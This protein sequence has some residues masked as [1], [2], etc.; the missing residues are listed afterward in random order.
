[1]VTVL[2]ASDELAALV[3]EAI[4]LARR[5]AAAPEGAASRGERRAA[6]RLADLLHGR[7]GVE[8][9]MHFVD[10]VV[11]PEDRGVAARELARLVRS[12]GTIVVASTTPLGFLSPADRALLTLGGSTAPHAP[13]LVVPLAA[14]RVRQL[15]GHLVLDAGSRS[16][17]QRLAS[18]RAE[19]VQLNLN[20]L[21]EAVLGHEEADRRLAAIV[22]LLSRPDVDYVSVKASSVAAQLQ[23]WDLVGNRQRLV[24]R[25]LPL[26]RRAAKRRP[27]AFLNLDMEEYK[28]LRLTLDTFLALLS[29]PELHDLSAGIVLQTYLPDAVPALEELLDFARARQVAGGAPIKVR[30]VKGANL[31]MERVEA[32]LHGWPQAPYPTKEETDANYLR[33]LDLALRP[34]H[35]AVRIGVASHNLFHVAL[36]HLLAAARGVADSLDVEMLQGMAPAQARAVQQ[37]CGRMV[38]YTP[39]V[40]PADFDEAISYLVRRLEENAAP[41]NFLHA[42]F[43]H[44]PDEHAPE[45]PAPDQ[46]AVATD[47]L[48]DQE[49]RFRAAI[50]ARDSVRTAPR[51]TQNRATETQRAAAGACFRNEPD[52]DPSLPANRAWAAAALARDP[53]PRTGPVLTDPADVDTAIETARAAADSW[54]AVPAADRAGLLR[55]AADALARARGDLVSV[56]AHEAGKTVTEADPEVSEAIDF[57][58]YY[59]DRALELDAQPGAVFTPARVVVVTPPW[60]FPVAIPV[61]G[62]CAALAAG[63]TVILKPAPQSARCAEVA[64][65]ALHE[66]G[67]RRDVLQLVHTDEAAAGRRLVTAPPVDLVVLTGA[68]ETAATFRRWRPDLRVLAETSGKNALVV[69][70]AA[71][72]DLAV[73]DILRSAFGHAGQKCSAASLVITVGSMSR[74]ARFRRQLVDGVRSL[75]CGPATDLATVV[76]PLIEPPPGKL[77]RA[78][79]RLEPGEAWLV[80]PRRLDS[81]GRLWSPGVRSGVRPDSFLHLT[82]V[83]GPVLALMEA[84]DLDEAIDLQNATGFGLTGGLHSLDEDEIAHWLERVEVG[85]TYVNR[86]ITGAIVQRQSF[87]GWK[88][89]VVGPAAK[90]GGPNY[91]AQFGTWRD[92]D[93]AALPQADPAAAPARVLSAFA[94]LPSSDQDWLA[95]AAGSD[96][97][98]W[99]TV[100]RHETDPTGLRVEANVFRYRPLPKLCVR[101]GVGTPPRHLARALLAAAVAAVPGELGAAASGPLE[102][103][104]GLPGIEFRRESDEELARRVGTWTGGRRLRALGQVP[105]ELRRAAADS[106]TTVLDAEPLCAGRRELLTVLREQTISRT[107]H[108]F[109]YLPAR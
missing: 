70:P 63:S 66:A 13:S 32:E 77:E 62:V 51:R 22:E 108:R 2:R 81:S 95:R 72:I 4:A 27:Q 80:P 98:A 39:V 93:L 105:T 49:R 97:H 5:W 35:D 18:A 102:P 36:A 15:V 58:T 85:N 91:V 47:P 83:F 92:G 90:T 74:S 100:F 71:D 99:D 46:P 16:L 67:F 42:L 1:V 56:M 60:N 23:P 37:D 34:E 29:R 64:V 21:G 109:G 50:A 57:A 14:R 55:A 104:R 43:Q 79:T 31:S 26:Y 11:R 17:T 61:G 69:T 73:A 3:D 44:P 84:H 54:S 76:G 10:R 52:T 65:A 107:L 89:S 12:D 6:D 96:A 94:A 101:V 82:E 48:R 19:G 28:D 86:H 30:L 75:Q 41:Q 24:S 25:L 9:A 68:S 106:G 8:F 53:G 33:M 38:L 40:A 45:K 87:G 88:G 7:S 20:L 78:L 103:V 59:A